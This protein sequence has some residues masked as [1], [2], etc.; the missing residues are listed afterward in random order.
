MTKSS[1]ILKFLL[2]TPAIN[3]VLV[4]DMIISSVEL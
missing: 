3:A 4:S 1:T 2:G